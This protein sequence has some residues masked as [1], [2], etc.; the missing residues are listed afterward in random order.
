MILAAGVA[1]A[2]LFGLS[3]RSDGHLFA[4][5][6]ALHE[7]SV[8]SL[9]P[10]IKVLS[11]GASVIVQTVPNSQAYSAQLFVRAGSAFQS[12]AQDGVFHLIEHLM[13]RSTDAQ[14]KAE[15]SG[16][17]MN[18][19][20]YR[21]FTCYSVNGP[22]E[23]WKEGVRNLVKLVNSA[24]SLSLEALDTEKKVILEEIALQDLDAEAALDRSLW[25]AAYPNP[26]WNMRTSGTRESIRNIAR[27]VIE[28]AVSK[29]YVGANIIL[30]VAGDLN[31]DEVLQESE[32]LSGLHKGNRAEVPPIPEPTAGRIVG[33]APDG[34]ARVG[35]G[36]FA[37]GIK[38]ANY[39]AFRVAIECLTGRYGLL[40]DAGLRTSVFFGPSAN[41][42][43]VTLIV[44]GKDDAEEV[45]LSTLQTLRGAAKSL[46]ELHFS[47]AKSVVLSKTRATFKSPESVAFR[48]GL[49][50]TLGK[51]DFFATEGD[52]IEQVTIESVR[53]VLNSLQPENAVVMVWR[54]P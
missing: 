14:Y 47:N 9:S 16:S 27:D 31:G 38:D 13:F 41:G 54:K 26:P 4:A 1:T 15:M 17:W 43:L 29:H 44:S 19:T 36:F 6:N 53:Q 25:K 2:S 48:I 22:K 39:A 32:D 23:S 10:T 52:L 37:P 40:S 50:V 5:T 34:I 49:G 20:T 11:N 46:N 42:S 35:I 28:S 18:A 30:V 12:T 8:G 51:T 24:Q 21:E 33:Q 3:P 45:E 7:L